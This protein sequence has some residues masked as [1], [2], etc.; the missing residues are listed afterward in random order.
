MSIRLTSPP[1]LAFDER[2]S[3]A[4]RLRR[5]FSLNTPAGKLLVSTIIAL[6]ISILYLRHT[7]WNEPRSAFFNGAS[8]YEYRYSKHRLGEAREYVSAANSTRNVSSSSETSH[9]RP[10]ICAAMMTI[11]RKH[12]QYVSDSVGS[13]LAGLTPEERSAIDARLLFANIEAEIHPNWNE[14]WLNVLD[15]VS[16]I[17]AW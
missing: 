2:P 12:I 11:K 14:T 4:S 17:G 6:L 10:V 13:M 8:A 3:K 15:W 7:L 1:R 5:L 16:R 9:N